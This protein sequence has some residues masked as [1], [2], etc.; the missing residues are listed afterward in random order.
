[1]KR[2]IQVVLNFDRHIRSFPAGWKV[3]VAALVLVN[4]VVPIIFLPTPE[5]A[6]TLA[7]FIAAIMT[8]MILLDRLGFVRL[9]GIGHAPW[10]A[11]V[12]WAW[13]RSQALPEGSW[14]SIW[15][16][17]LVV[18]NTGSLLID[19][20]DFVRYVRGEREPYLTVGTASKRLL[21]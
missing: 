2:T 7:V 8:Q 15:L 11:L 16:I 10:L 12:P 21:G 18:L 14:M 13:Y 19:A 6:V 5:A 4:A 9:L 3:W 1:M 20:A 17:A